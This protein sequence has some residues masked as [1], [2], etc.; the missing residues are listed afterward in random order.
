MILCFVLLVY[1]YWWLLGL[2]H[3]ISYT[4]TY[5]SPQPLHLLPPRRRRHR[6]L[7]FRA[8]LPLL[9][10]LRL[11]CGQLCLEGLGLGLLRCIYMCV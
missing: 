8:P 2:V 3:I 10:H 6:R 9:N 11:Q 7:R 4:H 5:L 1:Y